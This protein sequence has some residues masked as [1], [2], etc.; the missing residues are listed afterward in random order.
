MIRSLKPLSLAP[1]FLI[2]ASLALT[3]IA[4]TGDTTSIEPYLKGVQVP[5]QTAIDVAIQ[6]QLPALQT[7][8]PM[9]FDSVFYP[10]KSDF[11][12][13][14]VATHPLSHS[15]PMSFFVIGDDEVSIQWVKD[16]KEA[17]KA[18]HSMGIL[19]N[20]D[21]EE[22]LD[23]LEKTLSI[24]LTPASLDGLEEVVHTGR[25]YPFWVKGNEVMQ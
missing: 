9:S 4:D 6:S 14:E 21:S 25:H 16:H 3:V 5:D 8:R 17:L 12:E 10:V 19:T 7:L 24:K 2:K 1:I 20:V 23:A 18:A 11:T 15:L 22:H 13:G